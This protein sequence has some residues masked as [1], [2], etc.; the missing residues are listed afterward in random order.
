[1]RIL[2]ALLVA[3]PL[4]T[5][6]QAEVRPE[7]LAQLAGD[8]AGHLTYVDYSSGEEVRIPAT[9]RV[10]PLS[11]RS[12]RVTF[13]YPDE[14]NMLSIDTM[15]L[16]SD[17]RMVDDMEVMEVSDPL[18]PPVRIVL[19]HDGT[20]NDQPARIRRTWTIGATTC[21]LRKGVRTAASD[22]FR[23]RHLYTFAR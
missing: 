11:D 22:D 4:L 9:L 19:E 17:G 3:L 1:M 23:Q 18:Y 5:H 7:L 21:T 10:E 14:P 13:N 8:M 16:S 6:A 20:D 15:V 12:W 2:P